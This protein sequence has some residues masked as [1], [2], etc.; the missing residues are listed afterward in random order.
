MEL[1]KANQLIEKLLVYGE[2]NNL[3]GEWDAIQARNEIR[4][5]LQ[6]T[7][8]PAEEFKTYTEDE[9]P[10]EP[11]PILDGLLEYAVEKSI[12]ND[13]ITEKDQLDTEIMGALTPRQ[14][15]IAERFYTTANNIG[16]KAAA[17]QYYEFAQKSNYIRKSRIDKNLNWKSETEYGQ[18]EI[19]INL[20]KPEKDPADIAAAKEE[21]QNDYPKC[22]LCLENVGYAGSANQPPRQNH[23]VV[24]LKLQNEDWFLQ[25][26]P[27]VYYNEHC[28]VFHREHI[29]M[30]IDKQTFAVLM[31]FIDQIPH[32]FIGSNADLPLVGGSILSHDHFQGG[33]HIFPMEEAESTDYYEHPNFPDVEISKLRW[34]MSVIRLKAEVREDLINLADKI[35]ENWREY[36]DPGLDILAFSAETG[37]K[38]AHNTITPIA[39]KK[40]EQYEFDLVLR[41]N[42][43]SEE[44]PDGIFHPHEELHHIKKENIGLIE[45][46]GR[47]ILPGRLKKELNTAAEYLS[48]QLSFE[49]LKSREGMEKHINWIGKIVEN[50]GKNL[51]KEEAEKILEA[52][53][54]KKYA[55]VLE[56]AGV[57]KNTENGHKGFERFLE[58]MGINSIKF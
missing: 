25:Y 1:H 16:I 56:D 27:Y 30:H 4:D 21:P 19:T 42:R 39:R 17:D 8:A 36:S 57:Y 34:P 3:L 53:T 12:I 9:I 50:H 22:F 40:N 10:E 24:P 43:C 33:R 52:E 18:L 14:S 44:H 38:K 13:T 7:A 45:V 46:M 5:I 15:E 48:N 32:Y 20:A 41:N 37:K 58:S 49:E 6:I 29:P 28:I 26:S 2:E 31:D 51:N 47:A 23:R 11:Q 55:Q 35:L 54:A